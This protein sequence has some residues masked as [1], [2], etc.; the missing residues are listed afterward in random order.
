MMCNIMAKECHNRSYAKLSS[1]IG[2]GAICC[3]GTMFSAQMDQN[4][5]TELLY[6][7]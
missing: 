7:L 4:Y 5:S 1:D 3:G 2:Q 6:E